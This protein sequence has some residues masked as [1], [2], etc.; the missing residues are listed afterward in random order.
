VNISDEAVD[1]DPNNPEWLEWYLRST[2]GQIV[3]SD[4]QIIH[5]G[6]KPR[7]PRS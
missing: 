4:K 2:V 7:A 3:L 1:P 6:R 5:N